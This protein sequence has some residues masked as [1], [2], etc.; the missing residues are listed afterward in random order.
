MEESA[1]PSR[2]ANSKALGVSKLLRL[3]ENV[4]DCGSVEP[5]CPQYLIFLW[6]AKYVCVSAGPLI[7]S[8][9]ELTITLPPGHL[10]HV[11]NTHPHS[12]APPA[13]PI[14]FA[15]LFPVLTTTLQMAERVPYSASL[16]CPGNGRQWTQSC[17]MSLAT[18]THTHTQCKLSLHAV[19]L[20]TQSCPTLCNPMDC[21][22]PHFSVHETFQARIL[23]WAA[24]SSSGI[25][26]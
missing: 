17:H 18:H 11:S 16:P 10:L 12:T 2:M 21:S 1:Q 4:E 23:E 24:I 6:G 20:V 19:C 14:W 8:P 3:R 22:L 7:C 13:T 15:C 25:D 5:Q 26:S 9:D